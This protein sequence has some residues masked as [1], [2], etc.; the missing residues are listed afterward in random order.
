MT[1]NSFFIAVDEYDC[2]EQ[3]FFT[4]NEFIEA[5]KKF[6]WHRDARCK[7]V[8]NNNWIFIKDLPPSFP[9]EDEIE[10]NTFDDILVLQSHMEVNRYTKDNF[11]ELRHNEWN[12]DVTEDDKCWYVG[13]NEWTPIR[14]IPQDFPYPEFFPY[15]SYEDQIAKISPSDLPTDYPVDV[16]HDLVWVNGER[17]AWNSADVHSEKNANPIKIIMGLF[18]EGLIDASQAKQMVFLVKE[19]GFYINNIFKSAEIGLFCDYWKVN[20]QSMLAVLN[21]ATQIRLVCEFQ[22]ILTPT[23]KLILVIDDAPHPANEWIKGRVWTLVNLFNTKLYLNDGFFFRFTNWIASEYSNTNVLKLFN[24]LVEQLNAAKSSTDINLIIK[25]YAD[26][27]LSAQDSNGI[28]YAD[29]YKARKK[30]SSESLISVVVQPLEE[31]INKFFETMSLV[32]APASFAKFL[33]YSIQRLMGFM[34]DLAGPADNI[35]LAYR[36]HFSSLLL[37]A[38]SEF[39][40]KSQRQNKKPKTLDQAVAQIQSL[41]GLRNVK[42]AINSLVSLQRFQKDTGRD[43]NQKQSNHLIFAGNPGTGKTTVAR[44][45]GDIF[46]E[47]GILKKGHLVECDR[48]SLVG[49]YVGW[50]AQRTNEVIDSALDG[51]LFI[52]EAYSLAQG[53]EN[54]FGREAID[55]L[56]KRME[57]NRNRLIVVVAGYTEDMRHFLKMNSG[58]G[59]RFTHE[60][61]FEDYTPQELKTIFEG[62]CS[63][64]SYRISA[65]LDINLI[66]YFQALISR[67][68]KKSFGNARAVRKK[69]EEVVRNHSE[70]VVTAGS[71]KEAGLLTLED[72]KSEFQI[73]QQ[74]STLHSDAYEQLDK[75][76]GLADVK[77]RI[78]SLANFGRIQNM[79]KKSG[80]PVSAINLHVIFA[81]NPG[82]GKTTVARLYAEILFSIGLLE[83][84]KV[85]ET[86]RSGLVASYVG[87]TSIKTNSIVDDAIGGILF[88]DEAYTLSQGG[89]SDFGLEA[90]DTL[91]K[92][93]EDD[94]GKFVVVMAGYTES[95]QDFLS[96]NPGLASRYSNTIVYP[97][98]SPV[99]LTR[100]FE[101]MA[102][103]GGFFVEDELLERFREFVEVAWNRRDNTFGNARYVRNLFESLLQEQANRLALSHDIDDA[104]LMTLMKQDADRVLRISL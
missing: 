104:S 50:T 12:S 27:F 88:I 60:I 94:R 90:I 95:M 36:D 91:V 21:V 61:S 67:S 56:I 16:I 42:T 100:I 40:E 28:Y 97:D 93:M 55:T 66:P 3:E 14:D 80:Y 5:R 35:K 11:A 19:A 70:L 6:T 29:S 32:Q 51:V 75:L 59:S 26:Y 58:L 33:S 71:T 1:D 84:P 47:L 10:K 102:R 30:Q 8:G 86:D 89:P 65:E 17:I 25:S 2:G 79:R 81:G 37:G 18:K 41:I 52:D 20:Q 57:D 31:W 39:I 77:D 49:K 7:I 54:D 13:L 15:Q 64:D 103:D 92:R 43:S 63:N 99:E 74:P 34:I 73:S 48:S 45:L 24:A 96:T 101:K 83:K 46:R 82:T 87:Q 85:I 76:V 78:K 62:Y 38:L 9:Y 4:R 68:E 23:D 72:L 53:G 98:Y 69:Y 22:K 44:L